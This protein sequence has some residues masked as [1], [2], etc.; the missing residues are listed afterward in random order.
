MK[1]GAEPGLTA[2]LDFDFGM[3]APLRLSA[4]GGRPCVKRKTW[5]I[6]HAI[7]AS[8]SG[9][10]VRMACLRFPE[11]SLLP[12]SAVL[13]VKVENAAPVVCGASPAR[14]KRRQA[15]R[16]ISKPH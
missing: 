5:L 16:T 14:E 3:E 15:V 6:P 7:T 2:I 11:G 13:R 9:F 1:N 10:G 12:F 4:G 8:G